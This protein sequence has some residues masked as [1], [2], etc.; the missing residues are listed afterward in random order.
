VKSAEEVVVFLEAAWD[1]GG[2]M[3]QLRDG[4]FD[5]D[6]AGKFLKM[7]EGIDLSE[8]EMIPKRLLALVWYLPSFL[9]WQVPRI[10]DKGGDVD[11]Y[12]RFV[13]SVHN[14][15]EAAFGAP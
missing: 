11:A 5:A 8:I 10:I 12:R 7:L 14:A 3:E 2:I 4:A 15:L 1:Q 9:N 13:T 6:R